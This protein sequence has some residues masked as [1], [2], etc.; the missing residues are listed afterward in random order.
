MIDAHINR[1]H[2][3]P[4]AE[5]VLTSSNIG[6]WPKFKQLCDDGK[7]LF[8]KKGMLR[9]QHGAPVGKLILVRIAKDGTPDYKE[10]AAEWFD[11]GSKRAQEFVWP[12]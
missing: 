9:Y 7:I 8:D 6:Q 2:M 11:P 4:P 10:S 5:I 1:S 3:N 12:E